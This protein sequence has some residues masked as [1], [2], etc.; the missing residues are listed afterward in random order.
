MI[1][2]LRESIEVAKGYI[3][4]MTDPVHDMNHVK[5]VV[6]LSLRLAKEFP[7]ADRDV[8]EIATWWHDVGR[9]FDERH[10]PI[11]AQVAYDSLI[12]NGIG[13]KFSKAVYDAIVFHRW[14][15]KPKTLEGKIVRDADKLDFINIKRWER[16]INKKSDPNCKKHY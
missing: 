1:V 16:C 5:S 6:S 13:K 7:I 9:L 12:E 4:K 15:M 3:Q 2:A 10:E 14:N 8:I 11:S